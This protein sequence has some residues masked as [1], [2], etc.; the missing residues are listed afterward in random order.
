MIVL[1]IDPG[2]VQ[3]G[4]VFWNTDTQSIVFINKKKLIGLD[5]NHKCI[6]EWLNIFKDI[7][8]DI[9]AIEQMQSY[10]RCVGKTVFRTCVWIGRFQ[11]IFIDRKIPISDIYRKKD[12][13]K[14]ICGNGNAKDTHVRAALIKRYGEPGTK[15]NQGKLYGVKADI[16]SALAIAVTQ[17]EKYGMKPSAGTVQ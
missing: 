6:E 1:G 12:V 2:N 5:E 14:H 10:G 9:I 3:T 8:P 17:S 7:T 11:Q 15:K 16:W 13:T 4:W